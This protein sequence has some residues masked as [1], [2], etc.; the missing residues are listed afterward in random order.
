MG[1]RRTTVSVY[2]VPSFFRDTNLAMFMLNFGDIISA[3][4]DR[5]CR[6]WRF[7]IMLDAKTV[8]SVPN[9][10]DVEGQRLPVTV[11]GCKS[12]CWHCGEIGHLSAVCLGKKALKKPDQN[13]STLPPVL[14]NIEKEAP[15]VLSTLTRIKT[16]TTPL[17]STAT[18][19]EAG[20]EWLT[21]GKGGRKIQPVG[22]QS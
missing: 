14:T 16:P 6:E 2:E 15:I 9:R 1:W 4:H 13:P 11:S 21:V 7:N 5:I 20:V 17:S 3:T 10:L 18:T 8:Y 12:A 19:K 22:P